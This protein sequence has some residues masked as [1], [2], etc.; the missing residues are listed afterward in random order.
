VS[1]SVLLTDSTDQTIVKAITQ[2]EGW[3]VE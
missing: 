3:Q 1:D 2:R